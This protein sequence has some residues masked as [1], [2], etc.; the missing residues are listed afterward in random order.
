MK[1]VLFVDQ[2]LSGLKEILPLLKPRQMCSEVAVVE[3]LQFGASQMPE[4]LL[5]LLQQELQELY[6]QQM[7]LELRIQLD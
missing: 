3:M 6:L 7:L 5:S 2:I 1:P 4:L